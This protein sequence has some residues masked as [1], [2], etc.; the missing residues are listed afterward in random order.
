[1]PTATL[2]LISGKFFLFKDDFSSSGSTSGGTGI[3]VY[4]TVSTYNDL[5][6]PAL[7]NDKIYVVLEGS[8][9]YLLNRK[10]A[11]LYYSDSTLWRRLGDIPSYFLSS[12]FK[13]IDS[14]DKTKGALFITSGVT[15]NNIRKLTIQDKDGVLANLSDL[16]SKVDNTV[17]TGYTATTAPLLSKASAGI[18]CE[19][20][21]IVSASTTSITFDD[22]SVAIWNN[23]NKAGNL[24]IHDIS[25][26]TITIPTGSTQYV[27]VKYNNGSPKYDIVSDAEEIN[28]SDILP[29]VTA[30]RLTTFIHFIHW[31]SLGNG[32]ANKIHERFVRT[33]RF[34]RES[35]LNLFVESGLTYTISEGK[36]W[37]G[38][39]RN[40][41]NEYNSLTD[42]SS[43]VYHV[44][45]A[46]TQ[47]TGV[48]SLNSIYYDDGTN[49][50]LVPNNKFS[51]NWIYRLQSNINAGFY[52][53]GNKYFD[54]LGDA[55]A[56]QPPSN[57]PV[58]INSHGILVGRVIFQQ[59]V[60]EPIL[61]ESAFVRTFI[62]S[63]IVDHG[64]FDGL[65]DDDH[66]QYALLSGRAGET[67]NT[68]NL[69]VSGNTSFNGGI[70]YKVTNTT[71]STYTLKDNDYIIA[72]NT[73]NS[74]VNIV[75]PT[76]LLAHNS[77]F[78]IKDASGNALN[79]NITL[80]GENNE[81]IDG[82]SE[83]KL[84]NNY[85]SINLFSNNNNW[86]IF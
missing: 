61:V 67:I 37:V 82:L 3:E 26:T 85:D 32:L 34:K 22:C 5:P 84:N 30:F 73:T 71:G 66:P 57:L 29:V 69:Y 86:L 20:Y 9:E 44:N 65:L 46:W 6:D 51:V 72:V 59:G 41:L 68:D 31:D 49:L 79:N 33:D 83:Y 47:T 8:G 42:I 80:V 38:A 52:I 64:S 2:D 63:Q 76:S 53:L 62:G 19:N 10:D 39:V 77:G 35:G 48:T 70:K 45:S 27:V 60:A 15:T 18:I 16:D 28:E 7:H 25:G 54:K 1:M 50:V 56:S 75:L 23:P 24:E 58:I 12:N 36:V 55:Q 21:N 11:G 14:D 43:F 78:I 13:I 81:T 40:T 17:F 4:P 74:S